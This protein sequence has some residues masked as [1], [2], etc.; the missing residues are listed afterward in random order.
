LFARAGRRQAAGGRATAQGWDKGGP[1]SPTNRPAYGGRA[2][3]PQGA[4][5][6][7]SAAAEP[8]PLAGNPIPA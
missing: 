1:E 3:R 7:R 5:V 2:T 4:A 8:P 6:G